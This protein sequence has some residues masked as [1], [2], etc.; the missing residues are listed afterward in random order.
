MNVKN[1]KNVKMT[2]QNNRTIYDKYE[3][4]RRYVR[5]YVGGLAY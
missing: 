4:A 1:V 5:S 3:A 2:W